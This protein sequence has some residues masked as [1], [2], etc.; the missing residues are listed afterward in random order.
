MQTFLLPRSLEPSVDSSDSPRCGPEGC[1]RPN[2]LFTLPIQERPVSKRTNPDLWSQL[3]Q[4]T[5]PRPA[6]YGG[7]R[8]SKVTDFREQPFSY[9]RGPQSELSRNF[10]MAA[11]GD[12]VLRSD[13]PLGHLKWHGSTYH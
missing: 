4:Q 8:P 13:K 5:S 11:S 7:G 3:Q 1:E 9:Q 6:A 10:K 12:L 2:I